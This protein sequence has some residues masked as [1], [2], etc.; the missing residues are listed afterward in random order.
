MK[1]PFSIS[2]RDAA[3]RDRR[4]ATS[5]HE[6]Y[7]S[8][9][10]RL[11]IKICFLYENIVKRRRQES[12]TKNNHERMFTFRKWAP[13]LCLREQRASVLFNL[14]EPKTELINRQTQ[15]VMQFFFIFIIR[16]T[17]T[18]SSKSSLKLYDCRD[19]AGRRERGESERR[20]GKSCGP[21]YHR[22]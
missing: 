17:K 3:T 13:R 19:D 20:E 18:A 9:N 21:E 11:F 6:N 1:K 14:F 22:R 16:S 5:R 10:Y 15:F 2:L 12:R 8:R 4:R 7:R